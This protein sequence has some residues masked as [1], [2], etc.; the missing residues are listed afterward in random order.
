MSHA[1]VKDFGRALDDLFDAGVENGCGYA[2]VRSADQ[3]DSVNPGGQR[4]P[5]CSGGTWEVANGDE[6]LQTSVGGLDTRL[7]N[8]LRAT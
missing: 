8:P 7:T 6:I 5:A 4:D 2:E 3:H 1:T